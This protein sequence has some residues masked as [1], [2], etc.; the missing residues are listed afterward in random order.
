MLENIK[1]IL[2]TI[3]NLQVSLYKKLGFSDRNQPVLGETVPQDHKPEML[4]I[5]CV[6][7]RISPEEIGIKKGSALIYRNIAA[8]VAGKDAGMGDRTSVAAT[9]EFAINKMHVKKIAVMGH[10]HCGGINA[11][12]S[13]DHEGTA[14][15]EEY[16]APLKHVSDEIAAKG[17]SLDEQAREM[18][19]E[20]VR[21]SLKNLMSYEVVSDAVKAG[22][23]ELNGWVIDTGNK[24][25]WEMD[26][27]TK[28]FSPMGAQKQQQISR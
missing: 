25:L 11:C 14:H 15:I 7:A 6:D 22:K 12:V 3:K 23:L 19:K 28:E 26:K 17:G 16:L 9:L 24:L 27:E 13:G 21:E 4:L 18:E 5:G 8:L 2:S 20:A 10:T 1:N